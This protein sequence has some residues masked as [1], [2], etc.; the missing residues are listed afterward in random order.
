MTVGETG[1]WSVVRGLADRLRRIAKISPLVVSSSKVRKDVW[2]RCRQSRRDPDRAS[3]RA[4]LVGL[5]GLMLSRERIHSKDIAAVRPEHR[6]DAIN[7]VHYLALRH[8]D[9][10]QLQRRLGELSLIHI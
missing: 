7:L 8:G 3:I 9:L 6:L 1:V 2:L 4:D 5:E 10:R